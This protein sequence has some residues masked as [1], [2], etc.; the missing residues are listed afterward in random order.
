MNPFA[1]KAALPAAKAAPVA[2]SKSNLTPPAKAKS[3]N[4]F[5]KKAPAM[6]AGMPPPFAKK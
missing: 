3:G 4:P 6:K 2:K 1:K 5:A